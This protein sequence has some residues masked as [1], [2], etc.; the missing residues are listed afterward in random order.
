MYF[1]FLNPEAPSSEYFYSSLVGSFFYH[2][3]WQLPNDLQLISSVGNLNLHLLHYIG[4]YLFICLLYKKLKFFKDR[5]WSCWVFSR[6]CLEFNK[7][8]NKLVNVLV[9]LPTLM[10]LFKYFGKS[11]LY[12]HIALACEGLKQ[13]HMHFECLIN[14]REIKIVCN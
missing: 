10:P 7:M 14:S 4:Y 3:Y 2:H 5:A 1:W 13:G 12:I 8:C 6:Q 9:D 11:C